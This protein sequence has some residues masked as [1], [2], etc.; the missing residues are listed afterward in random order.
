[1]NVNNLINFYKIDVALCILVRLGIAAL[2][3]LVLLF[4]RLY[5]DRL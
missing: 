2:N 4:L 5:R 1:M 3:I